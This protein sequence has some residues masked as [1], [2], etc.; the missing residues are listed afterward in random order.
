MEQGASVDGAE[1]EARALTADGSLAIRADAD[2]WALVQPWM[3]LVPPR[4]PAPGGVRAWIRVRSGEPAFA[5][6]PGEP[7]LELRSVLGWVRPDGTAVLHGP[8]GRVSAH[9]D[10]PARLAEVRLCRGAEGAGEFGFEVFAAFTIACAFLLG[11]LE[12]ALV[13]AAA[14]VAP[15]GRAWLLGGGTFSG[16]TTTCVNLIRSGWDYLADDQVVLSRGADGRVG[17]EGWPRRFNLDH[18]YA[19]GVSQGLRSRVDPAGF[20]P[21]RWRPGAPLGGL[22]FPRVQ[23]ELPTALAPLHPAGALS[24]LLQQSPW[25]LGDPGA[26]KAVLGL[27]QAAAWVPAFELRLGADTYRD[28]ARLQDVL[29]GALRA[30]TGERDV[31]N[32]PR[33]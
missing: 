1:P 31:T 8:A 5:P 20:G 17:V 18:G 11:R 30:R 7:A 33:A 24:S 23:A 21:G 4:P 3:P 29:G 32:V 19:Q 13:H 10:G 28:R 15:D 26:A 14:V 6:V 22:L 12:R 9:V 25:L 2:A 27:L 16:K